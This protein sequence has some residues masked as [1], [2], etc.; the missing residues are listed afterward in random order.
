MDS[1]DSAVPPHIAMANRFFL[2]VF[3]WLLLF[4]IGMAPWYGTLTLALLVG[5][6]DAALPILFL[7]NAPGALFSRMLVGA[8]L[9][10]L[11]GLN[12]DQAH[13]MTELHFG[14]TTIASRP[15][16]CSTPAVYAAFVFIEPPW[17][18]CS[19]INAHARLWRQIARNDRRFSD[20]PR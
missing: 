6:P 20:L 8:A 14:V 15:I 17:A 19:A 7:L 5:I 1:V 11:C 2:A 4:S 9:M 16:S 13:G 18:S 3:C 12:I 10:I